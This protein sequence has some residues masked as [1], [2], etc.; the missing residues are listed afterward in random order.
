MNSRSE[1]RGCLRP[2][3]DCSNSRLTRAARKSSVALWL[4]LPKGGPQ[5]IEHIR[6]LLNHGISQ[7]KVEPRPTKPR[8]RGSE[9]RSTSE[10]S[11]AGTSVQIRSPVRALRRD[12]CLVTRKI[13]NTCMAP[14]GTTSVSS[15][16][17]SSLFFFVEP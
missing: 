4:M 11:N 14:L 16:L 8:V 15:T 13:S 1:S 10:S 17:A 5:R 7:T 3:S 2:W 12:L 6:K 9:G